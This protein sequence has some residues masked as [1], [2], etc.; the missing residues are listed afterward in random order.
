MLA[1]AVALPPDSGSRRRVAAV[2]A[3]AGLL[4][5]STLIVL[6]A[7]A[8]PSFLVRVGPAQWTP[9][10][11][12]PFAGVGDVVEPAAFVAM[13][14]ALWLC[15]LAVVAWA[16]A[17]RPRVLVATIAALHALFAL[18]P[19]LLSSD[20]FSYVAYGRLGALHGIDPY[21]RP[22]LAEHGDPVLALVAHAWRGVESAYGPLFTLLTYALAPLGV[23]AAVW[24]LKLVA[25]AASLG[26]VA[27]VWRLAGARGVDPRQAAAVFGLN[28]LVL[29]YAVGGAH[30]DLLMLVLLVAGV[31]LVVEHRERGGAATIAA[32]T[33]VKASAVVLLPFALLGA[34]RPRSVLAGTGIAVAAVAAVALAAF[35]D[36]A[37]GFVSV[38]RHNESFVSRSSVPMTIAQL[39]GWHGIPAGLRLA[40]QAALALSVGGLLVWTARGADW[41]RAGAWA[42]V[43]VA[44]TATYLL[45]WY[46]IWALPLAAVTP[47]RRLLAA[48]L[49]LQALFAGHALV[50]AL[51]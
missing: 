7:A 18:A 8:S 1:D 36:H 37:G 38:L 33:A 17:L 40:A 28:P 51:S 22:P 43:A 3:L 50:A 15:Y 45:P 13:L 11:A 41:V 14:G 4:G 9:W 6:A 35:G 27:L 12:G 29:V 21:A 5:T 25:A 39:F 30:N 24:S 47:S 31:V 46:T 20:V 49:V 34:R 44:A 19:P 32:A 10:L 23:A 26:V 2:V 48:T 42:L 16:R